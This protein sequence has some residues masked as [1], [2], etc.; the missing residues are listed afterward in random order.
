[1]S[2]DDAD[3]PTQSLLETER[4]LGMGV[5]V[6]MVGVEETEIVQTPALPPWREAWVRF[7]GNGPA[8]ISLVVLCVVV[9][10]AIFAPFLHTANPL[11][12]NYAALDAGP[13]AQHWLGTDGVGRDQYSRLLYGLRIPLIVGVIGAVITMFL[14]TLIGVVAGYSGGL[15]DGLLSRLTDLIFAFPSFTLALIVVSLYGPALDPYFAGAGRVILLSVVFALVSWPAL[16]RFVRSLALSL[17]EQQFIEAARVS[18]STSW[19]I[20]YRHLLPN[21]VGL[22]MVQASFIVITV[23]STETTLSIFGLGVLPPS[24]DLGQML[25]DG[26]SRLD[27]SPWEVLAPSMALTILILALT[28][29]GDGLRDA[30]DTRMSR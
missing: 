18:G 2:H 29:V 26:V 19:Q 20:M 8:L 10:T 11:A 4:T 15:V 22:L 12:Q 5:A 1:M 27:Y 3:A 7:R 9:L 25:F 28:F 17:K 23:I 6:P 21:M 30:I 13:S 14:G 24:P 16:M